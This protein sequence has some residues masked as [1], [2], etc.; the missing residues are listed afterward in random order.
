MGDAFSQLHCVLPYFLGLDSIVFCFLK[1]KYMDIFKK[2]DLNEN[3]A[4]QDLP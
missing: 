4:I 2:G 3:L 1:L